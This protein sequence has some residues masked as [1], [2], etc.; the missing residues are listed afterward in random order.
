MV[1]KEHALMV[2][3]LQR[4][5]QSPFAKKAVVDNP[6]LVYARNLY[7]KKQYDA[8]LLAINNSRLREWEVRIE[9]FVVFAVFLLDFRHTISKV[10]FMNHKKR[11]QK[12]FAAITSMPLPVA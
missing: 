7:K 5:P 12:L 9:L 10:K 4:G 6:T 1:N 8:A 3:S 11:D 2:Q